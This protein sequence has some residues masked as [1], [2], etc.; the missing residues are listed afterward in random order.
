MIKEAKDIYVFKNGKAVS[1]RKGNI[2]QNGIISYKVGTDFRM[3]YNGDWYKLDPEDYNFQISCYRD[4]NNE[5]VF[6]L[7][8][9]EV[10]PRTSDL[11][12]E[13]YD[14]TGTIRYTIN[15]FETD[16]NDF[17]DYFTYQD[18]TPGVIW[19]AKIRDVDNT[20]YEYQDKF[21]KYL[22]NNNTIEIV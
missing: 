9:L 5:V 17:W 6:R 16:K 10:E 21:W 13:L 2:Y 12:L 20:S 11:V 7:T 22:L 1:L 14:E 8:T 15:I 18:L 4:E 3:F 19:T